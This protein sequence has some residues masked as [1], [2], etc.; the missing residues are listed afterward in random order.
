MLLQEKVALITGAGSGLGRA[1]AI[2]YVKEG[3]KVIVNDL[4][5]VGLAETEK[6]IKDLNGTVLGI[7]ADISKKEDIQMMIKKALE[8][9]GTVDIC[10]NNAAVLADFKASLDIT[11]EEW[12]LIMNVNVKAVYLLTNEILPH[13]LKKG[14]GTFINIASIGGTIAGVGD[15][16]Y[17]TSKHA[18]VGYTKQL[19]FNYAKDGIRAVAL[20][21]GLIDTPMVQ[22]AIQQGRPEVVRQIN[23]IPSEHIG[24]A[25]EVAY[26][27]AYL[28]SEKAK[29]ING[30][31]MKID[32]GQSIS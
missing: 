24:R 31:E 14:K 3:A 2:E 26:F 6:L 29:H 17:I 28:A 1:Q 15:A 23:A 19:A 10:V 7:V 32:G 25:E 27:S 4:N 11:E 21:P 22:Y 12:D 13:M 8:T 16:A 20:C 9:F 18:V 5:E 30:V